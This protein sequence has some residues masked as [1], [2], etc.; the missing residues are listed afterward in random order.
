MNDNDRRL[1]LKDIKKAAVGYEKEVADR[2][3]LIVTQDKHTKWFAGLKVEFPRSGFPHLVGLKPTYNFI[4]RKK[5]K[6][7]EGNFNPSE[8]LLE[9]FADYRAS[10]YDFYSVH[11]KEFVEAKLNLIN[12]AGGYL[13]FIVDSALYGE[14]EKSDPDSVLYTQT[15]VGGEDG[16][17][18]FV[19]DGKLKANVPNTVY[20]QGIEQTTERECLPIVAVFAKPKSAKRYNEVLR[21]DDGVFVGDV[22]EA[23][24]DE[25][26]FDK[27]ALHSS[28]YAKR[29]LA[30]PPEEQIEELRS[31]WVAGETVAELC[32][33]KDWRVALTALRDL[34]P[35]RFT[36]EGAKERIAALPA[37][38]N[39]LAVNSY[40]FIVRYAALKHPMAGKGAAKAYYSPKRRGGRP[41]WTERDAAYLKAVEAPPE[42]RIRTAAD[43]ATPPEILEAMAALEWRGDVCCA[44]IRNPS[45][46]PHLVSYVVETR[47][48]KRL[49]Y[50][51]A[52][53]R[54]IEYSEALT[55]LLAAPEE[56]QAAAIEAA[57]KKPYEEA[58]N[59]AVALTASKHDF[60]RST[61]FDVIKAA[62]DGGDEAARADL[63]G[64]ARIMTA[65]P[66]GCIKRDARLAV[67]DI[68]KAEAGGDAKK[69][70]E[71]R[72]D[73]VK[74]KRR[75]TR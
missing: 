68:A 44:L 48:S 63:E 4:S 42:E 51:A 69:M 38:V 54:L 37:L 62:A 11:P 28:L 15:M 47:G 70:R 2:S 22:I 50:A 64:A 17:I 6:L 16:F 31:K 34:R 66:D 67:A 65:D 73:N 52:R 12:G 33:S 43:P 21:L 39:E 32:R 5:A 75:K 14:F 30:A 56:V 57:E 24:K 71:V 26:K 19:Y 8:S 59:E 25:A 61:A 3:F 27:L 55:A 49:M 35:G 1:L 20:A 46:P 41:T 74:K 58:R 23:L 10:I 13:D 29:L 36:G 9:A 7:G 60:I 40:S 45:L 18:G 53:R 72:S